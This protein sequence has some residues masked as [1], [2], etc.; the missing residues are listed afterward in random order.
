MTFLLEGMMNV[1]EDVCKLKREDSCCLRIERFVCGDKEA[2]T[3][4]YIMPGVM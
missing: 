1:V 2:L 4:G 3:R